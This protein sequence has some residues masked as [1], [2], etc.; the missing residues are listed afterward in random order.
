MNYFVVL[1]DGRK[2]GPADAATLN[3]WIAENRVTRETLLEDEA[4]GE[5][6]RADSVAG[7]AFSPAPPP[8]VQSARPAASS[9]FDPLT[10]R[11][12]PTQP[13]PVK[14]P[15]S[16]YLRPAQQ[17]ELVDGVPKRLKG[18]F[19]FAAFWLTWVWGVCHSA[20]W[21]FFI[22][23]AV[24]LHAVAFMTSNATFLLSGTVVW[25]ITK[26]IF[27]LKGNEAAWASGRFSTAQQCL[28][29]Q[30]VWRNW[31]LAMFLLYLA[32]VAFVIYY[33]WANG[34]IWFREY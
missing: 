7:L 17:E 25:L 9:P 32:T 15:S 4:T 27:G 22:F 26:V 30:V 18:G 6:K 11:P 33:V 13:V 29:A 3:Q 19:N 28:D 12:S 24:F 21:T 10:P 2:F 1:D 23:T 8:V 34:M 5:R 16:T 31:A 14:A 20:Y